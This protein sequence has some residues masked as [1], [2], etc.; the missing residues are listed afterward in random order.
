[1]AFLRELR[2]IGFKKETV[3]GT[4]ETLSAANYNLRVFDVEY[5]PDFMMTLRKLARG[6]HSHD[7]ALPGRR[8]VRVKM[9]AE[10]YANGTEYTVPPAYFGLFECAGMK[11][12][13][14]DDTA[15]GV[16]LNTHSQ[17]K[18]VCASFEIPETYE[19]TS[20]SQLVVQVAGAAGDVKIANGS[21][22]APLVAEFDFLG[23]LQGIVERAP[24]DVITPVIAQTTLPD[25]VL[26]ATI[27]YQSH[28]EVCDKFTISLNN[29]VDLFGDPAE[30]TGYS[31]ARVSN[32]EPPSI[33]YDPDLVLPSEFN[34]YTKNTVKGNTGEFSLIV[35]NEAAGA[36]AI[37]APKAQVMQSYKP[38]EREGHVT[39]NVKLNCVRNSG[40]DE[41]R[42]MYGNAAFLAT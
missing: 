32:P 4:F 25:V 14:T 5:D 19:G 12:T 11:Q 18:N 23:K 7:E 33:E 41:L 30:D 37:K 13:I 31:S 38:G 20:P 10:I 2:T 28:A 36:I 29:K 16:E 17:Y 35:G 26:N 27:T 22:G 39:H 24:G 15:K 1:M 34:Y 40:N 6:D 3:K 9:K 8:S 42:I 21:I